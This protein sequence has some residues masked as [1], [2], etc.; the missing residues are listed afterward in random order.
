MITIFAAGTTDFTSNGLF[1]VDRIAMSAEI[2]EEANG[3]YQL[4]MELA[5]DK[6]VNDIENEMIVRAPAPIRAT[7]SMEIG[8][9]LTMDI[10]TISA[11][12]YARMYSKPS[13][14]S[15]VVAKHANG[16]EVTLIENRN[17][18]WARVTDAD[19][20][21][22]FIQRAQITFNRTELGL[23]GTV[24]HAKQMRD[25]L[26]R[27]YEIR[28]TL[29]GVTIRARH[30]FYDLRGNYI[31]TATASTDGV[32][33]RIAAKTVIESTIKPNPFN[34]ISDISTLGTIKIEGKNPVEAL[35]SD[36]GVVGVYGGEILRDNFDIYYS[37][38]I[39]YNR[40]VTVAYRK[41]V[42]GLD[43]E[44]NTENVITQIIPIGYDAEDQPIY[45]DGLYVTSA[46][47]DDYDPEIPRIMKLECTDVK[48]GDNYADATAVKA[49]LT[50]LARAKFTDEKIDLPSIRASV[51]YIDMR[52]AQ[53]TADFTAYSNIFLGDTVR[54]RHESYGF[55]IE[56]KCVAYVWD[57]LR[58][59]YISIELG[60]NKESLGNVR[61]NPDL[62][63]DNAITGRK[64]GVHEVGAPQIDDGAVTETKIGAGAVTVG[65]I[66]ANAIT[67]EKIEAGSITADRLQAALITAECGLIAESAIVTAQIADGSITDAKIVSLTANKLTA[68]TI[69]A[70]VITVNNLV[71]DNITTGTINGQR[72][73]VLGTEKLA[74][75]AVTGVKVAQDAITA[76]K[77]VAEA[78]TSVKIAAEAITANKIAAN[79]I[80]AAK[81]AANAITAEKIKAGEI[82][83]DKLASNVGAA[84]DLS[85]NV[86]I[87]N[88]VST[89]NIVSTINQ[90]AEAVSISATKIEF[91][92]GGSGK[93]TFGNADV[94]NGIPNALYTGG[95]VNQTSTS[96]GMS[97]SNADWAFW[98]GSGIFRVTQAGQLTASNA[99]ITGTLAA[100]S[101]LF[102]SAGSVFNNGYQQVR[103]D[104]SGGWARYTTSGLS[105]MYGSTSYSETRVYG[106]AVVLDCA[107]TGQS[108]SA[109]SGWWGSYSYSD[110]C[111]VCDQAGGS[112][113]S[114]A[115]N[116]GTT[117]NRWDVFWCDTV[118]YNTR[119]TSSSRNVKRDIADM[120]DM[121]AIIDALQPVTFK[122]NDSSDNRTRHGLIYEDTVGVFPEICIEEQEA[123]KTLLGIDYDELIAVL[124]NEVKA[125]RGRVHA[126]ENAAA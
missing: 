114:A 40:G 100:G 8:A 97:S 77:I 53:N 81:I 48:I 64:I 124:L 14:S 13:T 27:I 122:Y 121:G 7:P 25:Q 116:L 112:Y 28:P 65:K 6:C 103:V 120:H 105:A 3:E 30:I 80:T 11:D 110:V 70:S 109:R 75:G 18:T 125:L 106:G 60:T 85:S 15:K 50:A 37:S 101:W 86:A 21:E 126:L 113:D 89:G 69:D 95:K 83:A 68:G 115:G 10:Y 19:G 51:D 117:D 46:Y 41:N 29:E 54:I 32:A 72:I 23:I 102:N 39:G 47:I 119:S 35:L 57:C 67:A 59:E 111:L 94:Y 98:A 76:D 99:N 93:F 49:K 55:D 17:T 62:I 63:P 9:T 34:V 61:I 96:T 66:A 12:S 2:T 5:F 31:K 78:I 26:F 24:V 38:T 90:S 104:V 79:A 58:Q 91:S 56:A 36:E 107:S 20:T 43:V 22:G 45:I 88:I 44:I 108:V 92:N 84:L 82:T 1:A 123:G 73:P 87:R 33:G 74:D 16:E 71:A 118:H 4:E 42:A 52:K